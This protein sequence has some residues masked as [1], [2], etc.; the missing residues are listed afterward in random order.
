LIITLT[1]TI[2]DLKEYFNMNKLTKLYLIA[3]ALIFLPMN[4][5]A[6]TGWW[7]TPDG[8]DHVF[9]ACKMKKY[10]HKSQEDILE[11]AGEI[12]KAGIKGDIGKQ[13]EQGRRGEK[14]WQ[15]ERGHT[16]MEGTPGERGRQG[17][18]GAKGAK[19]DTG[20]RGSDGDSFYNKTYGTRNLLS[21][22][23]IGHAVSNMPAPASNGFFTS[24]GFGSSGGQ[25]AGA[26]GF[27]YVDKATSYKITYG[28]S[29]HEQSAG[30]GVG[31][32]F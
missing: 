20:L 22:M 32:H 8:E 10:I 7:T 28:R 2:K 15:G 27:Y 19:G 26:I 17:N 5:I 4:A 21:V 18:K 16:G 24:A 9:D 29:G 1:F 3:P 31:Y 13:G 11:L 14:G 12:K 23:A 25:N 30:V 6:G